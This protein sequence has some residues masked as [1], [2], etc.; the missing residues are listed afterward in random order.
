MTEKIIQHYYKHVGKWI[1]W[2]AFSSTTKNKEKAL[3]F[4]NN[5]LFRISVPENGSWCSQCVD[6]SSLFEY[7]DEE[8]ILLDCNYGITIKKVI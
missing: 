1:N 4:S 6:I 7:P 2:N 5:T 3:S 8:E